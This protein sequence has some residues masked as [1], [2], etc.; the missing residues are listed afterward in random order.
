[1]SSISAFAVRATDSSLQTY[2]S[3]P[4]TPTRF[5]HTLGER[6]LNL[7]R[8]AAVTAVPGYRMPDAEYLL[9][10]ELPAVGTTLAGGIYAGL[11]Q[12]GR[13]WRAIICSPYIEGDLPACAMAATMQRVYDASSRDEGRLNTE[14]LAYAGSPIAQE[15]LE[16]RI[17]GVTGWYIP[18]S[19]E[20]VI[21]A[22]NLDPMNQ[23]GLIHADVYWSSTIQPGH[24]RGYTLNMGNGR[25][26]IESLK[27]YLRLRL[28]RNIAVRHA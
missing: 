28:I 15:I 27:S 7:G 21:L 17:N 5:G 22:L 19:Q 1:M 4:G 2:Q 24:D 8:P 12:A 11:M 13:Q 9:T 23:A 25:S 20:L 14:A 18:S 26:S 3:E 10:N 6:S 16:A